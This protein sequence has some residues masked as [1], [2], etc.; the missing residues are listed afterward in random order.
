[1]TAPV[2]PGQQQLWFFDQL[3]P[4]TAF[5]TIPFVLDVT[6]PLDVDAVHAALDVIR[7]RHE[8]LRTAY[9][10]ADGA[11]SPRPVDGPLPLT[12]LTA[13]AD[14]DRVLA[15][16]AAAAIDLAGG[17]LRVTVVHT[18][19]DRHRILLAIHHIAV[20]G[21]SAAVLFREFLACYD[22]AVAGRLPS[23]PPLPATFSEVADRQRVE[24]AG[25]AAAGH[26]DWWRA[27]LADPPAPLELST[28][29][30]ARSFAAERVA[31]GLDT[32]LADRVR[33]VARTERVSPLMVLLTAFALLLRRRTGAT[34][35][36]LG[37]PMAGR[38]DEDS[39][40][41]VGYFVN[42]LP[43]RLRL[44]H[45][46]T[47]RE[48]L[49]V[50]RGTVLVAY[51]H[52]STPLYEVINEVGA[53]R[54]PDAHPLFQVLVATPPVAG[55]P[56]TAGG[57]TF[58]FAEADSGHALYDLD[59][60]VPEA[61]SGPMAGTVKF[62]TALFERAEVEALARQ[63]H[64]L[65]DQLLAAPGVPLSNLSLLTAA[66][67][68]AVVRGRNRTGTGRCR[69]CWPSRWPGIR[70]PWRSSSAR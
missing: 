19:P 30:G 49:A 25:P 42:V 17:P 1:M 60:Q 56:A 24:L 63:L 65:L 57:A 10:L 44:P 5:H 33:A 51:E 66:E 7:D 40:D 37:T 21:W 55:P 53:E 36:V 39:E 11:P 41:L 48:A 29:D 35:L 54:R 8:P 14:A 22:A 15:E 13:G 12:E 70:T 38:D 2:T 68:A 64:T 47:V 50:A 43:L 61:A 23:L 59:V 58:A 45:D 9:V 3:V 34:D 6:G 46:P 26:R 27:T 69:S 52:R 62:R 28:R 31:L 4:G 67:R 16:S 32:A 18:G 20:D